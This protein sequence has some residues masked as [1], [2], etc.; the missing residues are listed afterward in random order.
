MRKKQTTNYHFQ[1]N[2]Y[3]NRSDEIGILY[4]EY[5]NMLETFGCFP[6]R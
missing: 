6:D 1:A 4:Q 3:E 5:R 2:E